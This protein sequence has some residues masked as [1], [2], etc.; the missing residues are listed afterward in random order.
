LASGL[1][2]FSYVFLHFLNHSL[3]N[4]SFEAME[5]GALVAEWI[6]RGPVGTVAL[7]GAFAIHLSLAFWAIYIRRHLRMGWLEAG[8]LLLGFSIP[9]LIVSHAVQQR[10]SYTLFDAHRVYRNLLFNYFFANPQIGVRQIIVFTVAWLPRPAFVAAGQ[11][12]LPQGGAGAARAGRPCAGDGAARGIPGR[13]A[14]RREGAARPGLA[15]G[16]PAGRTGRR[17]GGQ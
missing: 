6:W 14:G 1:V 5:R 7:Y 2:L 10:L 17:S 13:P 8:R 4:I 15:G 3:G 9:A 11:D 16:V 12:P